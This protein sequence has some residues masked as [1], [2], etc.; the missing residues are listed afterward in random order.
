MEELPGVVIE[1]MIKDLREM[2]SEY[3]YCMVPVFLLN[4]PL[5]WAALERCVVSGY[6]RRGF[7]RFDEV[8][9]G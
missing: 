3:G 9:K 2:L 4:Y 5:V 7:I 1:S 6:L 8:K